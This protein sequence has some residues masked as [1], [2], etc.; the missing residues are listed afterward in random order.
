MRP[1]EL[2][3]VQ[4]NPVDGVGLMVSMRYGSLLI[5]KTRYSLSASF[6]HHWARKQPR[7]CILSTSLR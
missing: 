1:L 2:L 7:L 4:N 5:T 6:G 3:E